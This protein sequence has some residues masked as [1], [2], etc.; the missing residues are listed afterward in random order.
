MFQVVGAVGGG[1]GGC[2]DGDLCLEATVGTDTSAGACAT[3]DTIDATQG[4][5][6][7]FCYRITNNTG[8][9][10]DYHTLENNVDGT[11]FSLLNEPV[12]DGGTFQ[13]N[14][15]ETVTD[16]AT[17]NSTWTGQDVPP[18]YLAEVTT[19]GGGGCPDRIFADGFDGSTPPCDPV[20]GFI[21]IT[22]S[23]TPLGNGDDQAIAVTMPFSF[24]FYGVSSNQICVDN[25]GF[26]LFNTTACP[27]FGFFTNVS[28]PSGSFSA[29]AIMPLWDDFDSESGNVYTAVQGT[30]P[31][32][33]FIVEWFDRVH[34]SGAANTDGATFEVI[35]NEDGTIQFEYSDVAY[36]AFTNS[37]GD[38]DDCTNGVCATI[39]LQNDST[40]FNEFS[41]FQASITDNSGIL[42]TSTSPQVFT[43]TDSVT[44]NVG[45]PD[46]NV[47]P[48]SLTGTVAAGGSTTTPLD[49]Q[50]LGNR[51]LNW[52]ADEAGPAN[53]HFPFG[54]RYAPSTVRPGETNLSAVRPSAEWLRAHQRPTKAGQQGHRPVNPLGATT[55][56]FGCNIIS[57]SSCDYVSFDADAPQ[58]LNSVATQ[59]E[60]MFGGSFG[61][62]DFTKE[63][64]V[65]YPSGDLET[66]DTATGARTDIG[67][68]GFGTATRDIAWDDTTGTMFG[69]AINGSST[70]LFTVD[71]TT[72]AMSLVGTI[73]GLGPSSY[74]MGLAVDPSSGNMY[75]IEIL[76]SSLVAID[77]TNGN[78]SVIGALGYSTRFGQGLD[79]NA[80]TGTL[81]LASID[82]STGSQNMYTV[83][84]SSG[85]ASLIAPIGNNIIQLGSFAIAIPSGPC[86]T[87]T[88]QPWLSLNPTSGTTPGGSDTPVTV[89]INATGFNDGDT[90]AGTVCVRSND[91]DEHTVAVPVEYTVGGVGPGGIVDSGVLNISVNDDFTGLYINWLTGDTCTS[92]SGVFC[93]TNN[94][95]YDFNPFSGI[96]FFFP[97][98]DSGQ[99][100]VDAGGC[101]ILASGATVGPA[102]TFGGTGVS[103]SGSNYAAGN[104]AGF[105]GFSF[106]NL[107]TGVVNYGYAKFTTTAGDGFPATLVEYWY[108]NTGAAIAIP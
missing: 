107:D 17:Y 49:I 22:G 57:F 65:G 24:N 39:G 92:D 40:L 48:T 15:I 46:I 103:I 43:G 61:N 45:A 58:T 56:S 35:L 97:S 80:A 41:A 34:Y 3:T 37:S 23:G 29:P 90:L 30:T 62:N 27:S 16:T 100:V 66:V 7:N 50:N 52:T 67:P 19:G 13:F 74:V 73:S 60:I 83:D 95:G 70:D 5:Q 79:F 89:T 86:G 96:T 25:N 4:E 12:P 88:D 91:P 85:V 76:T 42:W 78:A 106:V 98:V 108:D 75:G 53:L 1:G 101:S 87:P 55:P 71:L 38:P 9:E 84:T 28:L 69:T 94:N 14:N 93:Q 6:L 20:S 104:T 72:G 81:Y 2:N 105:L 21:D 77:K 54:P 36:S 26:L 63:Y 11:I 51:D 82:Y 68:T 44:V 32:R 59:N 31:N 47:D 99:C 33:Q 64:V 10:L 8:V 18:G 102:S